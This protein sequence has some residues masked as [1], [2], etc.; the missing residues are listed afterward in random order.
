MKPWPKVRIGAVLRHR[1]EFI[2]IDD[3]AIY[4]RPRV[5]LH[6]QGI[7]LRDEIPGALIKTKSQ[8]VS[9]SGEFLV[10]EIDAKVGGF[11]IVPDALDGCIV[12]SH[13]FLFVLDE[14]KIH[15]RFLDYFIRTPAFEDQIE[16]QG[17]TNY[18]A[19]RPQH[20]LGYDIPLP[21]LQEQRR[22]VAR[23]EEL[24]SLINEARTLRQQAGK[25]A[26]AL[27]PSAWSAL[28]Q[29]ETAEQISIADLVGE[30]GLRNGKSVKSAGEG[31]QIRCLALSAMRN[32]RIDIH[33]SKPV[34]MSPEEAAAFQ[35]RKGDVYV[36]RGNGSKDLCGR[37]GF[38]NEDSH[39]VIFPDLFIQISLP[40]KQI[41]P[42]FFVAAWNSSAIRSVI[43]E[44]AKT[45]SGIWKINQG[46]ILSTH[47]PVP[48]LSEQHRIVSELQALLVEVGA[49]KAMQSKTAT[50]LNALLT[51]VLDRAFKGG[52]G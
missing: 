26:E 40:T 12:S 36:V 24:S 16:A 21:P 13:Y 2:T 38:V 31:S 42:E 48:P 52:L 39:G 49:M 7:V 11:G 10:A 46:H 18:A 44:K 8:Q 32:G 19:I 50:E 34:P 20:V 14:T 22:I 17:S 4:K 5:Q 37:A 15:R 41:L 51:A 43:E 30:T 1:K 27:T 33:D 35:V 9:R 47:V 28:S 23:V 25:Q 3:L 6:A 45:T 29:S